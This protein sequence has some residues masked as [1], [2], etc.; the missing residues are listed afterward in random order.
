MGNKSSSND[1]HEN[2]GKLNKSITS[3]HTS[4]L[5]NI[6]KCPLCSFILKKEE[7]KVEVDDNFDYFIN[8]DCEIK[9]EH[10]K[11]IF[12]KF[13]KNIDDFFKYLPEKSYLNKIKS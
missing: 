1:C 8:Y 5:L 6:N 3:F 7:N 2:I 12:D 13:K 4:C 11:K 10:N 9:D